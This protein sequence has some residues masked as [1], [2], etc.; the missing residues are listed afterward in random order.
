M[1]IAPI[2]VTFTND[3]TK[4][5]ALKRSCQQNE[6]PLE[7]LLWKGDYPGANFKFKSILNRVA[8]LKEKGYTHIISVDAFD[9]VVIGNTQQFLG[10]L[11][12]LDFP[13]LILAAE[14]NLFPNKERISEFSDTTTRWRYVNSPFIYDMRQEFP[15]GFLDIGEEDDQKYLNDWYL[16]RGQFDLNVLLDSNC[17]FFQTLYGVPKGTFANDFRNKETGTYPLFFH[18]NGHANMSW[19]PF[20]NETESRVLIG[21]PSAG[22]QRHTKFLDAI[23]QLKRPDNSKVRFVHGQSP[24]S[25]R[26]LIIREALH[27]GF[28][29]VFFI[30]D[31]VLVPSDAIHKLLALDEDIAVG[32]YLLRVYPHQPILFTPTVGDGKYKW[33]CL[34]D[35]DDGI[36]EVGN[37]GLGCAL[38]KIDV[39][40]ALADP[41]I[42]LGDPNPEEWCDDT[43]FFQKAVDAGFKILCDTS[44]RCGHCASMTVYPHKDPITGKW[45]TKLDT[46]GTKS[47]TMPQLSFEEYREGVDEHHKSQLVA[48]QA[49]LG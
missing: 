15:E 3:V 39:F 34:E 38:I 33:R 37:S 24:A 21:I 17:K 35:D 13:A 4:L 40:K 10:A 26:N 29:H 32:L 22:Y 16:D 18:G 7:I 44:V 48:K 20:G 45:Q 28:T 46:W 41:W 6:W 47:I 31:D 19:L 9:T 36:I 23:D 14:T 42:T 12:D 8:E 11:H 25:S 30:D 43:K 1:Q 27:Q 2:V 49:V 5:D